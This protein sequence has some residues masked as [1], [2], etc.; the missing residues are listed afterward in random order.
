MLNNVRIVFECFTKSACLVISMSEEKEPDDQ[1]A[2]EVD[3]LDELEK[4]FQHV[5]SDL[6]ADKSLDSFR[7][8]YEKI[9]AAF[10]QSHANNAELVKRC[11]ELN[12]EILAN[13]TKVN[14]ILKLSQ[15]DQRTIAGLRFEFEKAWKM[16]EMSQDKENKSR[17]IVDQLKMEISNLSKLADSGGA[18][19]FTQETSL[20]SIQDEVKSLN[21]E[22]QLQTEQ[23][24]SLSK[25]YS[26]SLQK[27]EETLKATENL[28]NDFEQL[29]KELED[30]RQIAKEIDA[31]AE[32]RSQEM[33]AVKVECKNNQD[34]QE[35]Y[36]ARN[37]KAKRKNQKLADQ[38]QAE[39]RGIKEAAEEKKEQLARVAVVQ[40][41]FEDK[42]R[43]S[44]RID[45]Q[46]NAIMTKINEKEE[47]KQILIKKSE[48]FTLKNQS[49]TEELAK[50]KEEKIIIEKALDEIH[51]KLSRCRDEVFKLTHDVIRKESQITGANR[52]ISL[53]QTQNTK[54]KNEVYEEKRKQQA[55]E[56]QKNGISND[57][58]GAKAE[59]HKQ[60]QQVE[61]LKKEI[62]KYQRTASENR[63]NHM[64]V[65]ADR[66]IREEE[67]G[68]LDLQLKETRERIIKQTSLAET[69]LQQR[70]VVLHQCETLQ[71]ECSIIEDENRLLLAD[72]KQMKEMIRDKDA[73]C[74]F[75]HLE[76]KRIEKDLVTLKHQNTD[77]ENKLREAVQTQCTL[78]NTL[79]RSR[80][81]R[82][83][84]ESDLAQLKRS[85]Q[86]LESDQRLLELSVHRKSYEAGNLKDKCRILTS[87]ITA[88][89]STYSQSVDKVAEFY[90]ELQK[91]I[92]KVQ[93][94]RQRT[95][96]SDMLKLEMIR[97][98][99]QKLLTQG[100]VRALEEELETPMNVHRWRFLE[101]TNPEAAQM[102][103]MTHV[104]RSKYM[105]KMAALQ[106]Y[107]MELK[108]IE[109]MLGTIQ[110]H[111]NQT[112]VNEHQDALN[113]FEQ[114]YRQKNK[115]LQILTG[116]IS[117]QQSYVED[118][119]T[120]VDL[121]RQQLR[122]TKTE[123]FIDKKQTDTLRAS[124]QI[125]KA[126]EK[127]PIIESKFIGGGFA[128]AT[129]Q[130]SMSV[131]QKP[132]FAVGTGIVIPKVNGSAQK[133]PKNYTVK[134]KQW[135]PNRKPLQPFL[136]TVSQPL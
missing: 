12:S 73:E 100:K 71:A 77:L 102:I 83:V 128:V 61:N 4:N 48:E 88:T 124:S 57:M 55:T 92:D 46:R 39:N 123:Y 58:L 89:S 36:V 70:D 115:Q 132:L 84:A 133:S 53:V 10:V 90:D 121:I 113:Y 117:G 114:I 104:L 63:S 99:K 23:I 79:M 130:R 86:R 82:D 54:Q 62:E 31:E 68:Q 101:G 42:I 97:L 40:K 87:T 49:C 45:E 91:E 80:Y 119:K 136:P 50:Q 75:E 28:K 38:V 120:T 134:P 85:N 6:V 74:V 13:S 106:R 30:Q 25:D 78:E 126:P 51:E 18:M 21:R 7:A 98:E 22:I 20:Q 34:I 66:K 118:Q 93:K 64:V 1:P 59:A 44:N 9:H 37:R 33:A 81:L 14:S 27:K 60:R 109:Q 107:Q 129:A 32:Q 17:D 29:T 127:A 72:I 76:K 24:S 43:L 2:Q 105:I 5:I 116:Q 112:S 3:N 96:H 8:E 110:K 95:N 11:R 131:Q 26:L 135:N 108:R 41:L 16:V 125:S 47:K 35:E 94:L 69:V 19:A 67:V 122:D 52:S 103:K 56:S 111:I 65:E 15:D